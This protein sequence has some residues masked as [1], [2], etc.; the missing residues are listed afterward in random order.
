MNRFEIEPSP[1][2]LTIYMQASF[3]LC[4]W[5]DLSADFPKF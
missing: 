4:K 5:I 1:I 3:D 2:F